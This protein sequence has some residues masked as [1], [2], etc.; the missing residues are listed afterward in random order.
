MLT[1]GSKPPGQV[2]PPRSVPSTAVIKLPGQVAQVA[3]LMAKIMAEAPDLPKGVINL[4]FESGPDGSAHLV[5]SQDVPVISFTGSTRT[6][7]AVSAVRAARAKR[8]G[9]ELGGKTR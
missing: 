7:R 8:F 5:E 4:F 6:G 1:A 9:L 3:H 2:S